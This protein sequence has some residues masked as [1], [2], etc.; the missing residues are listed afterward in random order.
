MEITRP[1]RWRIA[2]PGSRIGSGLLSL[3]LI[4]GLAACQEAGVFSNESTASD[5]YP[6]LRSVPTEARPSSSIEERRKIV[7]TLL[8]ERDQSRRQTAIVRGRSGLSVDPTSTLTGGDASPEEIVPDDVDVDDRA[9]RLRPEGGGG[10]N[11]VYRTDSQFDDGGLDDFIRQLKRDTRTRE[12]LSAPAET[13]VPATEEPASEGAEEEDVGFLLPT[14]RG[15]DGSPEGSE[16]PLL[17]A[18]F[19][20]ALVVERSE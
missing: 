8:E 20:P 14:L 15:A 10:A 2:V 11:S 3:A 13:Q 16:Q 7:R 12:P 4:C 17:L 19:A 6:S 5:G 1:S 9:F 18:A